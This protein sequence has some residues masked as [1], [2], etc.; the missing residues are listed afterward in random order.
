[1]VQ[2]DPGHLLIAHLDLLEAS[3]THGTNV[4]VQYYAHSSGIQYICGS[5]RWT[6]IRAVIV[7]VSKVYGPGVNVRCNS[8]VAVHQIFYVDKSIHGETLHAAAVLAS[9]FSFC[10]SSLFILLLIQMAQSH[11]LR[12]LS[13]LAAARW[14]L[15]IC[16]SSRKKVERG[17]RHHASTL[18]LAAPEVSQHDAPNRR[19]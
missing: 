19:L 10:E 12:S 18:T 4:S 7:C 17:F 16:M 11:L 1:M 13:W 15:F 6:R 5:V 3:A 9:L 14:L 2:V 8:E